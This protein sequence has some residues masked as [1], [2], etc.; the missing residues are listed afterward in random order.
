MRAPA[1]L[2]HES[3]YCSPSAMPRK[4]SETLHPAYNRNIYGSY[5]PLLGDYT[6]VVA[7]KMSAL[8]EVPETWQPDFNNDGI[9]DMVKLGNT[10]I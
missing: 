7:Q 9:R 5:I 4:L 10:C 8:Y 3:A 1:N 6:D 2:V